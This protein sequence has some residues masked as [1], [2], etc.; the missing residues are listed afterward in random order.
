MPQ[1]IPVQIVAEH[2]QNSAPAEAATGSPLPGW[3]GPTKER[4]A[5]LLQLPENWDA[6]GAR[7]IEPATVDASMMLLTR[8]MGDSTPTPSVVP[9]RGGIQLEWHTRGI[10]LEVEFLSPERVLGIFEDL[11]NR[12][13]WEEDLSNDL[14]PLVGAIVSLSRLG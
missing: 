8:V 14:K 5:R 11:R 9:T 10:D 13:S 12:T 1:I 2:E 3:H 7:R 6:C 4:M